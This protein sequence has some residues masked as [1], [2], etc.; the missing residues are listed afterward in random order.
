MTTFFVPNTSNRGCPSSF[1]G[2]TCPRDR[3]RISA[4]ALRCTIRCRTDRSGQFPRCVT[5]PRH[6]RPSATIPAY[7][8]LAR[9]TPTEQQLATGACSNFPTE[10]F[11]GLPI[12][13]KRAFPLLTVPAPNSSQKYNSLQ[14]RWERR[15]SPSR[16]GGRSRRGDRSTIYLSPPQRASVS[17]AAMW[18]SCRLAFLQLRRN[19]W[20]MPRPNIACSVANIPSPSS[21]FRLETPPTCISATDA[22]PCTPPRHQNGPP[23]A[24]DGFRRGIDRLNRPPRIA[25]SDVAWPDSCHL[26]LD[27]RAAVAG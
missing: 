1:A 27:G 14:N 9:R 6:H 3:S 20:N 4:T 19:P 10:P 21:D 15:P 8:S 17:L 23:K 24:P 26:S 7:D 16:P 22:N 12:G 25:R 18:L 13:D 2:T 11:P 5:H